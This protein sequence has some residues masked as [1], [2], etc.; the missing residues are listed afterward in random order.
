MPKTTSTIPREDPIGDGIRCTEGISASKGTDNDARALDQH[1][2][3]VVA[4]CCHP[5]RMDHA[6]ACSKKKTSSLNCP[7]QKSLF[8]TSA[9][10]KAVAKSCAHE[11]VR[12]KL[13]R[14]CALE[15]ARRLHKRFWHLFMIAR[16]N[17]GLFEDATRKS[18]DDD[19]HAHGGAGKETGVNL[20]AHGCA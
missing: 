10:G 7:R 1:A 6:A 17:K 9:S 16:K 13:S 4:A 8:D 15:R 18:D 11:C 19:D 20:F 2:P 12:H 14:L 5:L 3:D